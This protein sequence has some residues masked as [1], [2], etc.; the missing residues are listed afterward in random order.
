M[1]VCLYETWLPSSDGGSYWRDLLRGS[2][3]II[4]ICLN[5][6]T[7][8][9]LS[10]LLSNDAMKKRQATYFLLHILIHT[11]LDSVSLTFDNQQSPSK[12]IHRCQTTRNIA[13]SPPYFR[14]RPS[15]G[16]LCGIPPNTMPSEKLMD[17]S[18]QER[19][20]QKRQ[21][22][23]SLVVILDPSPTSSAD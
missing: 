1:L 5:T 18:P 2:R 3:Q 9:I 12:C 11:E 19:N 15:V 17:T 10:S 13:G 14:D 7:N 6:Q 8:T 22:L 4:S 20:F 23:R 16:R 21:I